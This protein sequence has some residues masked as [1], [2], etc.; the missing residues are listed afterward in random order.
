M[1]ECTPTR[2]VSKKQL[3]ADTDLVDQSKMEP[4]PEDYYSN[5]LAAT[6]KTDRLARIIIVISS[7]LISVDRALSAISSHRGG[8]HQQPS[9]ARSSQLM[10]QRHIIPPLAGISIPPQPTLPARGPRSTGGG[11]G[12]PGLHGG[13]HV[14]SSDPST[15]T[16][17]PVHVHPGKCQAAHHKFTASIRVF[18]AGLLHSP[19]SYSFVLTVT[20]LHGACLPDADTAPVTPPGR[21]FTAC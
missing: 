7:H 16:H 4:N 19:T 10:R 21:Q 20:A 8:K 2:S 17:P 15:A 5:L 11:G 13:H 3:E 18:S 1:L 14:L 6:K 12:P 9:I